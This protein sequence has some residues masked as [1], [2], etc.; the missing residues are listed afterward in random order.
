MK[1]KS[2]DN[3]L[4][5]KGISKSKKNSED[6]GYE[7]LTQRP[8]RKVSKSNPESDIDTI[9]EEAEKMKI[10][11]SMKNNLIRLRFKY[12]PEHLSIG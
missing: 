2:I 1:S 12:W 10:K 8:K 7:C 6:I 9:I 4:S 11:L 3:K 5:K